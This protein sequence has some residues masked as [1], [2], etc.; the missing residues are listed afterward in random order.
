MERKKYS[1]SLRSLST[2]QRVH[3]H[4]SLSFIWF[5]KRNVTTVCNSRS[6]FKT[7]DLVVL[8]CL[9]LRK[10]FNGFFHPSSTAGTIHSPTL[11]NGS[12]VL[13]IYCYWCFDRSWPL[14]GPL[15]FKA[16]CLAS[17]KTKG[18]QRKDR[19]RSLF[20]EGNISKTASGRRE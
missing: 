2:C 1:P 16:T 13:C 15:L 3:V 20:Q 17:P 14:K 12:L 6:V 11:S 5:L 10:G 4:V 19:L 9:K 7:L 18:S 8:C